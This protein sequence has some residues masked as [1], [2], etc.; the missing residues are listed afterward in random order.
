MSSTAPFSAASSSTT[1]C[2]PGPSSS[3]SASAEALVAESS[4][5][6]RA[7]DDMP[8]H[9]GDALHELVAGKFPVFHFL[10]LVFPVSGELWRRELGYFKST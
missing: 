1:R 4:E 8:R 7:L 5:L 9:L 10:K 2:V 6:F 3:Q